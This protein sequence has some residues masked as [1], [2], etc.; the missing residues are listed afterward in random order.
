MKKLL[1]LILITAFTLMQSCTQ[2]ELDVAPVNTLT[3]AGVSI[4]SF[5]K[6]MKGFVLEDFKAILLKPVDNDP[7][8]HLTTVYIANKKGEIRPLIENFEVKQ[9]EV[10]ERGIYVATNY[11][12]IAFFVKYDNSWVALPNYLTFE[13]V[14]GNG[15]IIFHDL[16]VLDTNLLTLYDIRPTRVDLIE[17]SEDLLLTH[18]GSSEHHNLYIVQNFKTGAIHDISEDDFDGTIDRII[19]INNSDMAV[20]SFVSSFGKFDYRI[21]DMKTGNL[22]ALTPATSFVVINA[23]R[24]ANGNGILATGN[25]WN[26]ESDP[27][28]SNATLISDIKFSY[29]TDGSIKA[30][31]ISQNKWNGG[32]LVAP[33]PVNPSLTSLKTFLSDVSAYTVEGS[34]IYFSGT[35]KSGQ[36]VTGIFDTISKQTVVLSKDVFSSIHAL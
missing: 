33:T 32:N 26:G 4:E 27:D 24:N 29:N 17:F 13:G 20:L 18:L 7:N 5:V 36:P 19:S 16:T 2:D 9:I 25:S 21:L 11:S 10:T 30:D 28:L 14:M 35:D 3:P 34:F 15:D 12:G 31:F 23:V 6:S 8:T 1:S 22:T